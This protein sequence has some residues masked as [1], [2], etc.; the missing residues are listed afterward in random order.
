M[1]RNGCFVIIMERKVIEKKGKVELVG[2]YE[3][4]NLVCAY[5]KAGRKRIKEPELKA[6]PKKKRGQVI[7]DGVSMDFKRGVT[8][9]KFDNYIWGDPSYEKQ[10]I[11]YD[12]WLKT[13]LERIRDYMNFYK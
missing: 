13:A 10:S 6:D 11:T 3:N 5:I 9:N 8:I 12:E 4:G 2:E 1:C 7:L